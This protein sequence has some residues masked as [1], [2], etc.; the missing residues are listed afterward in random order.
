MYNRSPVGKYHVQVCTTTPCMLCDS[1]SVMAA[2]E[3]HLG[4]KPG[5]TTPD[6]LF[7][8]TEVECL[9]ACVNGMSRSRW[10]RSKWDRLMKGCDGTV[11]GR[12]YDSDQ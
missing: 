7:T 6:G 4:I 3:K 8:F 1:D 2:V 10:L 11:G 9:G 5:H 12:S